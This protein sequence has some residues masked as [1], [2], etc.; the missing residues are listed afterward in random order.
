[1]LRSHVTFWLK[2]FISLR[3]HTVMIL[4]T[5]DDILNL[6]KSCLYV[7]FQWILET[8]FQGR[9][10]PHFLFW[11]GN[12]G[13]GR[14][15]SKPIVKWLL[16]IPIRT[17]TQFLWHQS[18]CICFPL[19]QAAS[20]LISTARQELLQFCYR[21]NT[22]WNYICLQYVWSCAQNPKSWNKYK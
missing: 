1:M 21:Q 22:E 18:P 11:I 5:Y 8:S 3:I 6:K 17:W 19:H 20:F 10:Y 9:N 16:S 2:P 4:P 14:L 13:A 15:N 7:S 12:V